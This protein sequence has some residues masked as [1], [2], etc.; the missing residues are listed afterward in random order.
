LTPI[1]MQIISKIYSKATLYK[2]LATIRTG[3]MGFEYHAMESLIHDT[4]LMPDPMNHGQLALIPPSLIAPY[5]IL[6]G[7]KEVKLYSRSF[8]A[9]Y[10]ILDTEKINRQTLKFFHSPKVIIRGIAKHLTAA[11]DDQ[12]K[13]LLVAIHG[14][15]SDKLS[16][17]LQ[18]ALL[19]SVLFDWL[20]RMTF[21]SARIPRGSLRYPISF[22]ANL[23]IRT[24]EQIEKAIIR[25]V[26]QRTSSEINEK[27]K[28]TLQQQI[29][30]TIFALYE[31][32]SDEIDLIISSQ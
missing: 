15:I 11:Y 3:I 28:I 18:V 27:T 31:L 2:D 1:Q 32:T 6:W 10:L 16:S 9:P 30:A 24:N 14:A 7:K 17:E 8:T 25:L 4:V 5:E 20:H 19:N 23:P 12:G 26:R 13:A 21:Y 29:D 22:L